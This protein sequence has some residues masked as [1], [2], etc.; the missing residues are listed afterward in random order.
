M[1]FEHFDLVGYV[2]YEN[3]QTKDFSQI[4]DNFNIMLFLQIKQ[5]EKGKQLWLKLGSSLH[6]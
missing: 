4:L 3:F 6:N 1:P 2:I 5:P